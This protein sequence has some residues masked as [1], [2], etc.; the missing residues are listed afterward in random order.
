MQQ[1]QEAKQKQV[2]DLFLQSKPSN[3]PPALNP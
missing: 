2:L 1:L 3:E